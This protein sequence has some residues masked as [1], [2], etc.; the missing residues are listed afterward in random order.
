MQCIHKEML[1]VRI[2]QN[3]FSFCQNNINKSHFFHLRWHHRRNVGM[4]RRKFGCRD[5]SCLHYICQVAC[6]QVKQKE[7]CLTLKIISYRICKIVLHLVI[8]D[9]LVFLVTNRTRKKN[10][11]SGIEYGNLS[12]IFRILYKYSRLIKKKCKTHKHFKTQFQ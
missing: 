4:T 2:C 3:S 11:E 10:H 12:N 7:I 1:C 9:M 8:K 5:N 6:K